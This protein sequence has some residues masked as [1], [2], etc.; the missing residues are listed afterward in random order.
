M[1]TI[2]DL[3]DRDMGLILWV[4][5]EYFIE[6]MRDSPVEKYNKGSWLSLLVT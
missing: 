4:H 5:M 3:L 6:V 1:K 2:Q